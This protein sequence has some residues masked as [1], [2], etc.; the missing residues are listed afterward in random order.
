MQLTS[1]LVNSDCLSSPE[2]IFTQIMQCLKCPR[3]S[4]GTL[5][6]WRARERKP[7]WGSE[8]F[9]LQWDPGA[10]PQVWGKA[11]TGGAYFTGNVR[12]VHT[13]ITYS[14]YFLKL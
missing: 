7:I 6:L 8:G 4:G 10:K 3:R 2:F 14:V 5:R 9:S 11:P 1:Y 13:Y 12:V